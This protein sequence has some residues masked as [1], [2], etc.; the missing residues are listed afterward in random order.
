MNSVIVAGEFSLQYK[1]NMYL[2]NSGAGKPL[3]IKSV[4]LIYFFGG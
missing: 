1:F 2:K 4:Y 3:L